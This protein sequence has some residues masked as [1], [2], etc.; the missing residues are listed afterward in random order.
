MAPLGVIRILTDDQRG[1]DDGDGNN[2]RDA[3]PNFLAWFETHG[4]FYPNYRIISP[5]CAPSRATE[6]SSRYAEQHFCRINE[7]TLNY[8]PWYSTQRVLW[9]AEMYNLLMSKYLWTSNGDPWNPLLTWNSWR[10]PSYWHWRGKAG[11]TRDEAE[12]DVALVE[13]GIRPYLDGDI[14]GPFFLHFGTNIPHS[15][16][17]AE[18]VDPYT[19]IDWVLP[20]S[21]FETEEQL[22]LKSPSNRG[23]VNDETRETGLA[24]LAGMEQECVALDQQFNALLNIFTPEQ[25]DNILWLWST[26]NGY[27]VGEH[28]NTRKQYP[29]E[30]STRGFLYAAWPDGGVGEDV[31]DERLVANLDINPTIL[32]A[33]E[34]NEAYEE[35]Q[36]GFDVLDA[37]NSRDWLYH[38]M[39][40]GGSGATRVDPWDMAVFADV[41]G[42]PVSK[43]IRTPQADGTNWI[44]NY[45][46]E[47]DPWEMEADNA[48]DTDIED[49]MDEFKAGLTRDL[50]PFTEKNTN[51]CQ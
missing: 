47:A 48:V 50:Y 37:G 5:V 8:K 17:S 42:N 40:G 24:D 43:Y 15:G 7:E 25:R 46:L 19:P 16:Y 4:V 34:V 10:R 45:D 49:Q 21:A 20:P 1:W 9:N 38:S 27:E 6:F 23:H 41:D 44:E 39:P 51:V 28:G 22:L 32:T 2:L 13:E 11:P 35:Y 33:L 36:M 31:V 26:D 3:M 29:Y 30:G 12:H 18:P 14:P